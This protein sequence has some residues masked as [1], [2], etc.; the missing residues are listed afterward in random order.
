MFWDAFKQ[1]VMDN[2]V[3]DKGDLKKLRSTESRVWGEIGC[4]NKK[5][6]QTVVTRFANRVTIQ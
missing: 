4:D 1:L 2:C 6:V 5:C 3:L